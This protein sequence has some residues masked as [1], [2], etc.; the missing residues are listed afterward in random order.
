MMKHLCIDV[1]GCLRNHFA[2][3]NLSGLFQGP[4]GKALSR[5]EAFDFLCDHLSKGH[6]VIPAAK[7]DNF[8][9]QTGC[10]GHAEPADEWAAKSNGESTVQRID[11]K[12][13]LALPMVKAE[14][15]NDPAFKVVWETIRKWDIGCPDYYEGYTEALGN[16]AVLI[17]DALRQNY[18]DVTWMPEVPMPP[19][20][21]LEGSNWSWTYKRTDPA[22]MNLN[23]IGPFF[24][25]RVAAAFAAWEHWQK[26]LSEHTRDTKDY[27]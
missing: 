10:K 3:G 23:Q 17:L 9:Y 5:W 14:H 21:R 18:F 12:T 2:N 13:F 22:V 15:E 1:R 27:L 8:D 24:A 20:Y 7:C 25:H 26:R 19:H 6:R 11:G 4:D 16:H